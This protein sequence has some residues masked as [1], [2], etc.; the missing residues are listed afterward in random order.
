MTSSESRV[1]AVLGPTNTG[2]THLAVERM[3][4]HRSGMIGLPLRLL[5]REIYDRVVRLKGPR[6]VALVTGEEKIVPPRAE[7]WVATVEAMPLDRPVAFLAV[8]EI[9]LAGDP[10]RGHVFTDRLLRARGTEETM[11]LGAETIRPLLRRLVPEAVVETRPRMSTLRFAGTRK[12]TRLKP[13]SA[14]V[15]FSA[16]SVYAIAE[17]LRRQRGGTALVMGALSPRTRNAQVALFQSGE[18]DYLVATDAIGMGLNMDVDHVAFAETVKFDGRAPRRLSPAEVAQIGGRAGRHM[19]DGS[20]GLTAEA[21]PF[22]PDTV[23]RVESHRFEALRGLYWRNA[24]LDFG[25]LE[26]LIGSLERPPPAPGLLRVREAE[27][28]ASLKLL[29]QDS[30]IRALASGGPRLRLLW[31]VCRIPDFRKSAVE[32]HARLLGRIYR[33]LAGPDEVLPGDWIARHLAQLDRTDGDIDTL[34]ARIAHVRTWTYV[35]HRAD[36]VRGAEAWQERSRGIEDRLSDALHERLTQ[37]FVDRR[38]AVLTRSLRDER[39]LDAAIERD[40]TVLVEGEVLGRLEGFRFAAEPGQTGGAEIGHRAFKAAAHRALREELGR[41]LAALDATRDED[42]ALSADAR[43]LWRG[44]P[45][46]RLRPGRSALAPGLAVL[47]GEGLDAE[48]TARIARRLG[49]WLGRH[50]RHRLQ[51]LY[52]VLDA[53]LTGEAKG[54]AFRMTEELGAMPRPVVGHEAKERLGAFGLRIGRTVAYVPALLKPDRRALL[55]QLYALRHGHDVVLPAPSAVWMAVDP[56]LPVG[57]Y[58]AI[59]F[60]VVGAKALR[61]DVLERLAKAA[62]E[63]LRDG[64]LVPTPALARIAAC[65]PDDLAGALAAA[66]YRARGR[67]E[68]LRFVPARKR[69]PAPAKRDTAFGALAGLLD[70]RR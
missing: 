52:M 40:G 5:A 63:G 70:R 65:G 53:P 54:V 59:G 43:V 14:V 23:E 15:A 45:V 67:G 34:L 6:A 41:R 62:A 2:K 58:R 25:A 8:D 24:D 64:A 1:R 48:A 16:D 28:E 18:V 51:A 49:D 21:E 26:R 57:F 38:A 47:Q 56:R 11:F 22:D 46:A 7:Y 32:H 13:R 66:G 9:Q 33:H 19:N 36:W 29:A 37:R 10:E 39:G 42:L 3:L 61:V 27:D 55:G 4:G 12:L 35:T 44:T 17:L 30:E 68:G 50:L 20:F 69:P 60:W 31:E